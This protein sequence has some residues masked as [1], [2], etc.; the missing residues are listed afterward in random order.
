M[1]QSAEL[2]TRW[3]SSRCRAVAQ[4]HIAIFVV[5]CGRF[6]ENSAKSTKKKE[7]DTAAIW[8][9]WERERKR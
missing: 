7:R 6:S 8:M 9:K 5:L 4:R 2:L 3:A 1:V